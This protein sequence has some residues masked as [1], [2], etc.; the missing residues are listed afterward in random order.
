[1]PGQTDGFGP[2][3][4]LAAGGPF[5]RPEAERTAWKA[6]LEARELVLPELE[7][8]RQAK[9]IGKA[10]EASLVFARLPVPR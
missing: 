9:A 6:L 4:N 10:L 8:A 7:K 3:V 1:M 5:E 2:S